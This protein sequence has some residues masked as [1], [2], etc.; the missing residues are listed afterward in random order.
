MGLHKTGT[1]SL[2]T[3]LYQNRDVLLAKHSV[4]Y[5]DLDANLSR[6]LFAS[7]CERPLAYHQNILAGVTSE[8]QAQDY[9]EKTLNT[10]KAELDATVAERVIISGEDL[11]DLKVS[12][13]RALRQWLNNWTDQITVICVLREPLSWAESAAQSMI[14]GGS[15]LQEINLAPPLPRYRA[16]LT[17]VIEVFGKD[18]VDVKDYDTLRSHPEGL[19]DSLIKLL[20]LEPGELTIL[21]D[22]NKNRSMTQEAAHLVSALNH[23]APLIESSTKNPARTPGDV[24]ELISETQGQRF[25]LS[26]AAARQVLSESQADLLWLKETLNLS[27]TPLMTSDPET[28]DIA[29]G[30]FSSPAM[31]SIARQLTDKKRVK[32]NNASLTNTVIS[33]NKEIEHLKDAVVQLEQAMSAVAV[34]GASDQ[35]QDALRDQPTE[36]GKAE[37]RSQQLEDQRN[38]ALSDL[39]RLEQELMSIKVSTSWQITRPLRWLKNLIAGSS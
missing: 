1:T 20:K 23:A 3:R 22:D 13:W 4:L 17:R 12:E 18:A 34:A 16:K 21:E 15:T 10:L 2:Q 25:R 6:P 39:I 35:P 28:K 11:S 26:D 24:S 31:E 32:Q 38:Q 5:P 37:T 36:Q 27:I 9:R 33:Q 14:K 29:G 19:V 30:F 8:Q 7:F